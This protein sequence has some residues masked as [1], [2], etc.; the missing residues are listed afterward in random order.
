MRNVILYEILLNL[1]CCCLIR[2]PYRQTAEGHEYHWGVN[3]LSH[4][5]MTQLLMPLLLR[6][7]SSSSAN[8]PARVINLSSFKHKEGRIR[9]DDPDFRSPT[10]TTNT[11]SQGEK[12][13]LIFSSL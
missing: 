7:G 12:F 6:G 10:P 11:T 5:V 2:H 1:I 4:F 8:E 3:Y 9:W 13:N